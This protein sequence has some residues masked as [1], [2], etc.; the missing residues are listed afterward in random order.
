MGMRLC[1]WMKQNN[2]QSCI[3]YD[4]DQC[5][6][7]KHGWEG[8]IEN[9]DWKQEVIFMMRMMKII[10]RRQSQECI[11][12][13]NDKERASSMLLLSQGKDQIIIRLGTSLKIEL[14][15]QVK[16]DQKCEMKIEFTITETKKLK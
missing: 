9:N 12:T 2:S 10:T 6:R 14:R 11:L 8:R 7:F 3:K 5:S 16:I 1:L 13:D 4:A 15:S